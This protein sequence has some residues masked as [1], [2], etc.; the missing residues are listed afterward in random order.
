MG[1]GACGGGSGVAAR[2]PW[3]TV[4]GDVREASHWKV[5][6][7]GWL[8]LRLGTWNTFSRLHGARGSIRVDSEVLAASHAR[9]RQG[10]PKECE[11][12]KEGCSR[13]CTG[14][15]GIRGVFQAMPAWHGTSG[16]P[17]C[18]VQRQRLGRGARGQWEH[19]LRH[20]SGAR[21]WGRRAGRRQ[22]PPGP[23]PP[24]G[25]PSVGRRGSVHATAELVGQ[26]RPER[27][28]GRLPR[29]V[30][31]R[32]LPKPRTHMGPG[33]TRGREGQ[34]HRPRR[35]G[36]AGM[37]PA[38]AATDVEGQGGGAGGERAEGVEG[39]VGEGEEGSRWCGLI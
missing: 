35:R 6:W 11:T 37:P 13:Q 18:Q 7:T 25:S 10:H 32:A 39:W 5:M 36:A 14:L 20:C 30:P 24:A 12:M 33:H 19:G 26:R 2:A 23:Q 3:L 27:G 38:W 28:S 21:T 4:V 31:C 15:P 29:P 16:A 17:E 8:V 22:A 34:Q 1:V 9:V